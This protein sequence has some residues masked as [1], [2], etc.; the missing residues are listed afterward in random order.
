LQT[1]KNWASV[2]AI[3][4]S[5]PSGAMHA[6]TVVVEQA[7]PFVDGHPPTVHIYLGD[8]SKMYE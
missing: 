3:V 2:T 5:R 1:T 4:T 6:A 8:G 7:D